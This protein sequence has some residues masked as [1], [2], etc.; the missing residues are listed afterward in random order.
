MKYAPAPLRRY[1][2]AL[3]LS[4]TLAAC[5]GG[6]DG[7]PPLPPLPATPAAGTHRVALAAPVDTVGIEIADLPDLDLPEIRVASGQTFTASVPAQH[8]D[9]LLL[10]LRSTQ[11]GAKTTEVETSDGSPG[12]TV[13]YLLTTGRD[14]AEGSVVFSPLTDY[15]AR[16]LLGYADRLTPQRLRYHQDALAA[17]LIAHDLTGDGV[18]DYRDALAF[19][20]GEAAHRVR[21]AFDY[22]AAVNEPLGGGASLLQIYAASPVALSAEAEAQD[23][24]ENDTLTEALFAVFDPL[25]TVPLPDPSNLPVAVLEFD[26]DYGGSVAVDG[27]PSVTLDAENPRLV[28]RVE[29]DA[30]APQ[31]FTLRATPAQGMQF[32]RW[33][34]CPEENA[35]G[36]CTVAATGD[37]RVGAQFRLDGEVLAPGIAGV[38]KLGQYPDDAYAVQMSEAGVLRVSSV[39]IPALARQLAAAGPGHVIATLNWRHPLR[40][41]TAVQA[42]G[43]GG[44]F[45][46]A[47]EAVQI[48]EV[49]QAFSTF[50]TG[51]DPSIDDVQAVRLAIDGGADAP[52]TK[53]LLQSAHAPDA[54]SRS[55]W[56]PG[57]GKALEA[58]EGFYLAKN[59]EGRGFVL[60]NTPEGG[61][62]VQGAQAQQAMR[63][64]CAANASAPDCKALTAQPGARPK[65]FTMPLG[66]LTL[67]KGK[68]PVL[69]G[70]I[71]ASIG[72]D[73]TDTSGSF[74]FLW[75][76]IGPGFDLRGNMRGNLV[77]TKKINFFAGVQG[78]VDY[79]KSLSNRACGKGKEVPVGNPKAS[80]PEALASQVG[81]LD[82]DGDELGR[83]GAALGEAAQIDVSFCA[84]PGVPASKGG[85]GTV[86][87]IEPGKLRLAI[88]LN[89][90]TP[91][92]LVTP[93]KLGFGLKAT[94]KGKAGL[95][96]DLTERETYPY[97]VDLDIGAPCTKKLGVTACAPPGLLFI[98]SPQRVEGKMGHYSHTKWRVGT[99]AN[100]EFAPGAELT[101]TWGP[102][103]IAE[104]LVTIGAGVSVP[105]GIVGKLTLWQDSNFP[106][107]V[108]A[109]A[110]RGCGVG[111]SYALSQA[112]R[113]GVYG[114]LVPKIELPVLPSWLTYELDDI[115]IFNKSHDIELK[116][117]VLYLA[118]I[119][120]K[121]NGTSSS[122]AACLPLSQ[123]PAEYFPASLR[124]ERG[125]LDWSEPKFFYTK[126]RKLALQSD[127]NF[128][129]YQ[130]QRANGGQGGIT[131]ETALWS[132]STDGMP[133]A[134]V[135][136]NGAGLL[137][138]HD[139]RER[140]RFTSGARGERLELRADGALVL[141]DGAGRVAWRAAGT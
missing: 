134:R 30:Q 102:R 109:Q 13:A 77:L 140:Q 105:M 79:A 95:E 58:G 123:R 93:L 133:G 4:A 73:F 108:A 12:T 125:T 137:T 115:E 71:K 126:N 42:A 83:A 69:V 132:S 66:E 131:G 85:R 92:G 49:Y 100:A 113:L 118:G 101:L 20:P 75:S 3:A 64:A 104:G 94:V 38:V 1:G 24:T 80:S 6:D 87:L 40:R 60:V 53:A 99:V 116:S 47:T 135:A 55:V 103:G 130:L 35:D 9:G 39:T 84:E 25:E 41:I 107:D 61:H 48:Y 136:F 86:D 50:E 124:W 56:I 114:K 7:P 76:T 117:P 22:A 11:A 2:L 54:R 88:Q 62:E 52:H 141:L 78:K 17:A 89:N 129:L 128:V 90:T 36:S 127:G 68:D 96:V 23:D 122:N 26:T 21:L 82:D 5:G 33:V 81:K 34:G 37:Q 51:R 106:E 138:V 121:G 8:V 72:V 10:R 44:T 63:T 14:L 70:K 27:A 65:E 67:G 28:R 120:G 32:A 110:P 59:P 43:A 112:I 45:Q 97:D 46:F 18:V 74:T 57:Y 139:L 91:D 31:R 111:Y 19:D 16:R 98:K 119:D 15:I 29:I